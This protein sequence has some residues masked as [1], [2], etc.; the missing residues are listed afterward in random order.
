MFSPLEA[1]EMTHWELASFTTEAGS[2]LQSVVMIHMT[3][4]ISQ[5]LPRYI[6]LILPV[7][8]VL[9]SVLCRMD[10]STRARVERYLSHSNRLGTLQT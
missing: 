8:P 5:L 2:K 3:T 9:Q 4:R 1:T 7:L 10:S 6:R